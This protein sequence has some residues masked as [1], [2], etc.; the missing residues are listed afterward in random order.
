MKV[1]HLSYSDSNSGASIAAYRI[2]RALKK[3][4]VNSFMLV[5]NSFLDDSSV[6]TIKKNLVRIIFRKFKRLTEFL[7]LKFLKTKNNEKHSISFYPSGIVDLINNSDVDVVHLH[8]IQREFLSVKDIGKINKPIVWTFHDMWGICGCEHYTEEFRWKEGYFKNNRPSYESGIDLNRWNWERKKKFWKKPFQIV[9]ASNWQ[10]NCVKESA[11]MG[12]WPVSTIPNPLDLDF[13]KPLDKDTSRKKFNLPRDVFLILFG[14]GTEHRKGFELLILSLKHLKKNSKSKSKKIELVIFG[15]HKNKILDN[16]LF[17][18]H[19]LG[20]LDYSDS[21][22]KTIYCAVDAL[23]TPTRQESFGL[24]AAEAQACGTP[25]ISFGVGG[26]LDIIDHKQTG[27]L[28]K[29]FDVI[30]LS[31]GILWVL[32]QNKNKKL[33]RRSRINALSKFSEDKISFSYMKI[34]NKSLPKT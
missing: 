17:P 14:A 6:K 10:T 31:E 7:L 18:V 32:S 13:W 15:P 34:Y 2:H 29:P 27:Y 26:L 8:W 21:K 19:Y 22:L 11:L 9:T 3:N 30:D 5:D 33:S 23:V 1:F 16:S 24:T 20:D 12:Q 4:G 25:V 28:A